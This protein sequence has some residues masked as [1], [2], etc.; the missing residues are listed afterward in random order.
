[1]IREQQDKIF[2]KEINEDFRSALNEE[3]NHSFEQRLKISE[4]ERRYKR[5]EYLLG[6]IPWE[7]LERFLPKQS[8]VYKGLHR[9]GI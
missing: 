2:Q 8:T 4:L 5:L 3:R 9:V 1:M 7:E 6:K